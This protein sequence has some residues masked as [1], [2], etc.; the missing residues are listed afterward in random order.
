VILAKNIEGPDALDLDAIAGYAIQGRPFASGFVRNFLNAFRIP[1]PEIRV[2]EFFTTAT[3]LRDFVPLYDRQAKRVIINGEEEYCQDAHVST[4][5]YGCPNDVGV[6]GSNTSNWSP[7]KDG[8][9]FTTQGL[10]LLSLLWK[11]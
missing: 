8:G 2:S 1:Y 6:A 3:S 9:F 10:D 7:R 5:V 11:A 4:I